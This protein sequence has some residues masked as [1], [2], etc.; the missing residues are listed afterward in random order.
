[1]QMAMAGVST[2]IAAQLMYQWGVPFVIAG[3]VAVLCAVPIGAAFAL[4]ALRTRG[5]NLA[6]V[7]LGFGALVQNMLLANN[8]YVGY[9]GIQTSP[10]SIFG[11]HFDAVYHPNRY[12][13]FVLL[14]FTACAL[15]IANV[16]RGK[17]GGALIAVRTNER[18]AAALGIDVVQTK[19]F[20]F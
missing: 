5:V 14:C 12:A 15:A 18:A 17:A 19:L 13:F 1:E 6:V 8:K 10:P 2:L 3:I 16:R 11:F 7:T 4:P 9:A 20:A